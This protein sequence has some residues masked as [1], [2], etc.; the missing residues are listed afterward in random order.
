MTAAGYAPFEVTKSPSWHGL[1]ALDLLFNNLATG[2]FLV[3]AVAELVAP[4]TFAPAARL[5]YPVA[6]VLLVTDLAMLVLD[7][8]DPL[9]FHHMLRV[10]K[11]GSP[12]SFGTWSLTLFSFPLAAIVAIEA[13]EWLGLVP[14][15]SVA[16]EWVRKAAVVV[17]LL[18]AFGSVAYKGVLFSTTSQ[19]GW[20]DARWLGGYVV[21]AA[22]LLGCAELLVVSLLGGQARAA[23][24]LRIPL[25]T[26]LVLNVIPSGLLFAEL[27]G[28]LAR[29]D[30]GGHLAILVLSAGAAFTL[31]PFALLL[32]NGRRASMIAAVFLILIGAL[33]VRS[34][35]IRI[36]HAIHDREPRRPGAG[37]D[38]PD[39]LG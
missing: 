12:M 31:I 24:A 10:F 34:L 15:W 27:R 4:G 32:A 11:P 19:P 16:L 39:R 21:N 17:A 30:P 23:A 35:V 28:A 5:A 8:G 36:P 13:V 20:R 18:P 14:G 2:L 29:I 37:R 7:L 33:A 9:R 38:A 26:L 1:V 25:A 3:A 6:L 22:L